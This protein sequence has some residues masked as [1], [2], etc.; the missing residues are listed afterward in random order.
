MLDKI[1]WILITNEVHEYTAREGGGTPI[2]KVN[3]MCHGLGF[4]FA[5]C[6]KEVFASLVVR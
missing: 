4:D 3:D 2:S 1:I 6:S 5:T